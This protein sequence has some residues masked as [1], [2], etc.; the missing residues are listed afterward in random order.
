MATTLVVVVPVAVAKA[1]DLQFGVAC[2][3]DF[4]D[5]R[6]DLAACAEKVDGPSVASGGLH[7]SLEQVDASDALG[8]WPAEESAGPHDCDAVGVHEI[9]TP[10]DLGEARIVSRPRRPWRR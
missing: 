9:A 10:D 6:D 7:E 4:D 5:S 3:E 1:G 2:A 8:K